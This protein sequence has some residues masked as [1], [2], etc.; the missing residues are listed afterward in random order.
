MQ[1]VR[2]TVK[3]R[4]QGVGF[5]YF[6]CRRAEEYGIVGWVKNLP[7]GDVEALAQGEPEALTRFTAALHTGPSMAVV[8]DVREEQ[9]PVKDFNGFSI[10]GWG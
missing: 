7:N 8:T 3:G 10:K 9:V 2:L 5:R 4:V 1:A 6:V